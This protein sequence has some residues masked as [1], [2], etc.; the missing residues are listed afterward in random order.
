MTEFINCSYCNNRM[1]E[2]SLEAHIQRKHSTVECS[3]FQNQ[4][5][6]DSLEALIEQNHKLT[7]C[8]FCNH[9]MPVDS[10]IVHIKRKH[11]DT[12]NEELTNCK[13]QTTASGVAEPEVP[14]VPAVNQRIETSYGCDDFIISF[15]LVKRK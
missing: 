3:H 12:S 1:P 5:P 8:N 10:L 2:D 9:R 14:R 4:M 11:A 7:R 6:L 13:V 15:V